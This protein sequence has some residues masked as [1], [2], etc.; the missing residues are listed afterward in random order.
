[1]TNAFAPGIGIPGQRILT[2]YGTRIL[3]VH[4][5]LVTSFSEL[6]QLASEL[7]YARSEEE[8]YSLVT[9]RVLKCLVNFSVFAGQILSS[10]MVIESCPDFLTLS[11]QHLYWIEAGINTGERLEAMNLYR[12]VFERQVKYVQTVE[13]E[14]GYACQSGKLLLSYVWKANPDFSDC[15]LV[16]VISRNFDHYT[17]GLKNVL[18]VS[19]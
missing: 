9:R 7:V 17:D 13:T 12:S 6:T 16:R 2:Q 18:Q 10:G 5:T 14:P 15:Y 11:G 19:F 3:Y 1:M 8:E 4:S